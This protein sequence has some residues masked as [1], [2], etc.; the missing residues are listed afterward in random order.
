MDG[1]QHDVDPW[2]R[3]QEGFL[4]DAIAVLPLVRRVDAN[5]VSKPEGQRECKHVRSGEPEVGEDIQ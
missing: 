1:E 4:A 3:S 5:V 2:C